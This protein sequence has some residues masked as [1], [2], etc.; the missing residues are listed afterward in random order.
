VHVGKQHQV[1]GA[2]PWI[3]AASYVLR[4]VVEKADAGRVLEND[5]AVVRAQ[6]AWVRADG[7]DLD[8][9][10]ER[11]ECGKL[12]GECCAGDPHVVPPEKFDSC[13]AGRRA[14]VA[15]AG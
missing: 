3:V 14:T 13:L 2:E 6:L 12:K 5:R 1:N 4:R 8:V 11:R 7:R 9:L 15:S 10:C